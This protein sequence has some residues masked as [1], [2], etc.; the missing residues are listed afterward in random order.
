MISI[1]FSFRCISKDNFKCFNKQGRFFLSNEY[2]RFETAVALK[3]KEQYRG[4]VLTGDIEIYLKV[5]FKDKRHGDATNLFKGV[6][7]GLNKIIWEDDRQ[8]K[9][10]TVE[11]IYWDR[12]GFKLLVQKR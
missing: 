2:K 12:D 7:D 1:I 9:K 8:I 11:I 3:A 10:A 5:Y 6:C 4:K